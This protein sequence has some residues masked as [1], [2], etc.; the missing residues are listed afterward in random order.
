MSL[1]SSED[2]V[3]EAINNATIAIRTYNKFLLA[4]SPHPRIEGFGGFEG[5]QGFL[6]MGFRFSF[7]DL[8]LEASRLQVSLGQRG[9]TTCLKIS[10]QRRTFPLLPGT[11]EVVMP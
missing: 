11:F 2:L 10:G 7:Q 5:F 1:G 4:S 6:W 9:A 8:G 3:G